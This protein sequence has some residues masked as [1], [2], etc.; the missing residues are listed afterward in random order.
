MADC[1]CVALLLGL[2]LG[3]ASHP[4]L[5]DGDSLSRAQQLR[6]QGQPEVAI[7]LLDEARASGADTPSLDGL[8]GLCLL[9]A[10]KANRAAA[11]A[12][13]WQGYEGP[14]YRL[15]VFL[16]RH[17]QGLGDLEGAVAA[18][19][20][21]RS[22]RQPGIEAT[23]GLI[24]TQAALGKLGKAVEVAEELEQHDPTMGRRLA[25]DML[26]VHGDTLRKK[27]GEALP[28]AV[29]KYAA[30]HEKVPEDEVIARILVEYLVGMFR[31]DEAEA[32]I[33]RVWGDG[34]NS[35]LEQ[36]WRGLCRATV[37]DLEGAQRL[38]EAVLEED[39]NHA[40]T[41]LELAGL[42]LD[43]GDLDGAE[44]YLENCPVGGE[45]EGR[46]LLFLGFVS[47]NRGELDHAETYLRQ[48]AKASPGHVKT[49]Y[50]F[51]RLLMQQ[52]KTEEG[53]EV[54][55]RF[56]TLSAAQ[57]GHEPLR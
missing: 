2:L 30:A 52:G 11:L 16:G 24:Q 17:A 25:A 32:V 48:A 49:L 21:A 41:L 39:P 42:A 54:L 45:Q 34:K 57:A 47:R 51:G 40:P 55:A 4:L 26:M 27:G 18:Y 13:Q 29:E 22:L 28:T 46:R 12:S 23:I 1:R 53:R 50:H 38:F 9:D 33:G 15:Y 56:Q 19:E 8:L 36:Y 14:E 44:S 35:A 37:R 20:R 7:A 6:R 10:S 43:G 5:Q 3:G 31:V